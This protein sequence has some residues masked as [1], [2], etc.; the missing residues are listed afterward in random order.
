MN[1]RRMNL[2]DDEFPRNRKVRSKL[3]KKQFINNSP[4]KSNGDST[5]VITRTN[6]QFFNIIKKLHFCR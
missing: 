2:E 1:K 3:R 5:C 4:P 6:S